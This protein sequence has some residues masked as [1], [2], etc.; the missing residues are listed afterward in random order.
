[1]NRKIFFTIVRESLFGGRLGS[2][3]VE[4][5]NLLLDTHERYFP[6]LAED[7][8]AAVFATAYHET[9]RTMQP[10][11]EIGGNAYFK[12]MYDIRGSRPHVARELGNVFP[13]DGAKFPGMGFAQNTGRRNARTATTIIRRAYG[14]NVDFEQTPELL[15]NPKYSA[16]LLFYGMVHGSYTGKGL[17]DYIDNDGKEDAGEFRNS[18][19]IIN[20]VDRAELIAGY[21]RRF[22][23]AFQKAKAAPPEEEMEEPLPPVVTGKKFYQ[24]KTIGSAVSVM[25]AGGYAAVT[26]VIDKADV[27]LAAARKAKDVTS[28]SM[29]LLTTVGPWVAVLA[30]VLIAGSVIIYERHKKS[31]EEGI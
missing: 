5:M 20:G 15:M 21:A 12:R 25:G 11:K 18:R 8:L 10:I 7:S 23:V 1:M 28:G 30:V 29:E 27:A 17:D 26:E 16:Y 14:V 19:R 2:K 22:L 4:G 13:G 31:V 9:G 6:E 24:S 3:Q